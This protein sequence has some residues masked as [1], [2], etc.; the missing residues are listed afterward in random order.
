MRWENKLKW[1]IHHQLG[2][3]IELSLRDL[4][5]RAYFFGVIDKVE[6]KINLGQTTWSTRWKSE[7]RY[8]ADVRR[9]V[10]K[11]REWDQFF[12]FMVRFP[13]LRSSSIES[14]VE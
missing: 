1:Q 7:Y 8:Q 11:R 3:A 2:D 4:R 13:F 14:G 6:H 5:E 12:S 10:A 9:S